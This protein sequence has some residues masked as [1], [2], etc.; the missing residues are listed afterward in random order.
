MIEKF[1]VEFLPEAVEFMEG[2][3]KKFI[4]TLKRHNY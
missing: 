1:R 2:L 4:S 3:D